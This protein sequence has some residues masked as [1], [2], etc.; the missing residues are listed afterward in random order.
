LTSETVGWV[1]RGR[2]FEPAGQASWIGTHAALPVVEPIARG[3]RVYFC[4]RDEA[5]T[6]S[7][8]NRFFVPAV[9]ARSTT[10]G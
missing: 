2:I 9:W 8:T 3:H 6:E 4:S 7:R 1:K 5:G 10:P